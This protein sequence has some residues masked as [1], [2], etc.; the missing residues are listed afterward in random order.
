MKSKKV[1][2]FTLIEL[3]IVI[4][5]ISILSAF[6]LLN[7]KNFNTYLE[8]QELKSIIININQTKNFALSSRERQSVTFNERTY[9]SS[10][11][12][13]EFELKKI[14]FLQGESNTKEFIFTENGRPAMNDSNNP[15]A[16][17]IAFKGKE[18]TYL[19]K[20]RPVTG[21]IGIE[22]KWKRKLKLLYL[23]KL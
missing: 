6:A 15:T 18:K 13:E 5:I 23:W 19:L 11:K 2:G 17:T 4:A 16:G 20:L 1:K 14:E 22:E 12:N 21:K 10:I 9:T 3:V 8:K 7:S